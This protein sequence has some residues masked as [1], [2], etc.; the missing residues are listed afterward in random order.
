MV[1]IL[2]HFCMKTIKMNINIFGNVLKIKIL[3]RQSHLCLPLLQ[4]HLSPPPKIRFSP[5]APRATSTSSRPPP[6]VSIPVRFSTIFQYTTNEHPSPRTIFLY[7]SIHPIFSSSQSSSLLYCVGWTA[8]RV[9]EDSNRWMDMEEE[10]QRTT[11]FPFRQTTHGRRSLLAAASIF[12]V[13]MAWQSFHPLPIF[14]PLLLLPFHSECFCIIVVVLVA[15]S[16]LPYPPSASRSSFCILRFS[17]VDVVLKSWT[18]E[19]SRA[20]NLFLWNIIM[21]EVFASSDST[22]L[23]HFCSVFR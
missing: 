13:L 15:V 8:E 17:F 4:T 2:T 20:S 10:R 16:F 12:V 9:D 5:F 18:N 7:L 22:P 6:L 14:L 23:F 11:H 21:V 3:P 1:L 19:R